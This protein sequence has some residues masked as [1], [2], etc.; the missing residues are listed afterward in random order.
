MGHF[1]QFTKPAGG[2]VFRYNF[3]PR[4]AMRGNILVGSLEGDD[5]FSNS[6]SQQQRN[7]KFRSNIYE[8]SGQLEFNFLDYEIGNDYHAFPPIFLQG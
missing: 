1:N 7:L 6:Q 5:S 8:L 3:N 4:L 2:A